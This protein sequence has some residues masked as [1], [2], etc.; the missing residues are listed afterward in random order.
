MPREALK[1]LRDREDA[2]LGRY[3]WV[4]REAGIVRIPIERAMDLLLER[5]LPTRPDAG[6]KSEDRES[7][8]E[9]R[10]EGLP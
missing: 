5:G 2:A 3:G 7:N 1:R 4:D 8:A 6:T 10:E 9:A